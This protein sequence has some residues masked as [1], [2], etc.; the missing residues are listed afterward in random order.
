M[1][2]GLLLVGAGARARALAADVVGEEVGARRG[3]AVQNGRAPTKPSVSHDT[4]WRA[5]AHAYSRTPHAPHTPSRLGCH[6]QPRRAA[7]HRARRAPPPPWHGVA[8]MLAHDIDPSTAAAPPATR[9]RTRTRAAV[10]LL[11]SGAQRRS[12]PASV[13]TYTQTQTKNAAA[14]ATHPPAATCCCPAA[15]QPHCYTRSTLHSDLE[16]PPAACRLPPACRPAARC[17]CSV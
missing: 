5:S 12:T 15:T 8:R 13:Y 6:T 3:V 17:S 14:A 7:P 1:A 4:A 11:L 10:R 2:E 9:T 16:L